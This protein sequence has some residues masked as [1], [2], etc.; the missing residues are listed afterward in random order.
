VSY[1]DYWSVARL[2]PLARD[3]E[4]FRAF[5]LCNDVCL[6]IDILFNNCLDARRVGI[7]C[8]VQSSTSMC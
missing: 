6:H 1:Q 8:Q 2:Q 7:C 3:E 5:T 4:E